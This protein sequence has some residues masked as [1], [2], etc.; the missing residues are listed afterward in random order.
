MLKRL[1]FLNLLTIYV[2]KSQLVNG[3]V[4]VLLI[5][6]LLRYYNY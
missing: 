6:G 5:D 3:F 2:A 4:I 1:L